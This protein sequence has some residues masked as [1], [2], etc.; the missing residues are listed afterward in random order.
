[1]DD[2]Y[3]LEGVAGSIASSSSS[4]VAEDCL[5][6]PL[7]RRM[8]QKV[9]GSWRAVEFNFWDRIGLVFDDLINGCVLGAT[10]A[11]CFMFELI[12]FNYG[13]MGNP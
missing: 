1:M 3:G 12:I 13:E 4:F 6:T 9:K 5:D 7:P 10:A 11:G 8:N 2:S